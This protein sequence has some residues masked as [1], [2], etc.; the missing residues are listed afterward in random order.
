MLTIT[1]YYDDGQI[2]ALHYMREHLAYNPEAPHFLVIGPYDHLSTGG[3]RKPQLLRG[4]RIDAAAQFSSP[5][6]TFEWLDHVLKGGPRPELLRDRVHFQIMGADAWGSAPP[7]DAVGDERLRLY[8]GDGRLAPGPLAPDRSTGWKG[9]AE[10]VVD[11]G[12]RESRRAGYYPDAILQEG[13]E[14]STGVTYLSDP[15]PDEVT[16]VGTFE[17]VLRATVNKRDLDLS[18]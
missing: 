1:G 16:V 9:F 17:G 2:S 6:L 8:L 15:F 13:V 10:Q 4:Y 12:D 14:F 7:L 5:R 11:F 18:P 3:V